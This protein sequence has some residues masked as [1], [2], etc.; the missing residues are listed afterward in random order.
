MGKMTVTFQQ[1]GWTTR[2]AINVIGGCRP[3]II[4]RDLMQELG[5][6][7]VQA[8][9][10]QGVHN[11]HSQTE[12]AEQTEDHLDDWQRHFRNNFINFSTG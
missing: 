7:L 8:P 10:E 5:L 4:G 2:A 1:N 12:S 3:F 6:M 11:F 9:A